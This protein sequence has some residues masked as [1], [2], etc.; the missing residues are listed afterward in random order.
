MLTRKPRIK[1][2]FT[3]GHSYYSDIENHR[4]NYEL[5]AG[6]SIAM[7]LILGDG[8]CC[9]IT[10]KQWQRNNN[11]KGVAEGSRTVCIINIDCRGKQRGIC[12]T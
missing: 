7:A 5:E 8:S 3:P 1:L 11:R 9:H 12:S 4:I 2:P 6:G 10:A